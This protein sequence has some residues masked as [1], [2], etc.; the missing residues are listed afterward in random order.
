MGADKVVARLRY[1]LDEFKGEKNIP[2]YRIEDIIKHFDR[3][4]SDMLDIRI[5]NNYY[6]VSRYSSS[7]GD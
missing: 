4:E 3:E 7:I 5:V 1:L 2:Y 6:V